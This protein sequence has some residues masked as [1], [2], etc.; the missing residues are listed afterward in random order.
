[1]TRDP[2]LDFP[3]TRR[4]G[5]AIL[6]VLQGVLPPSGLVLEVGAG[7]G[8][9]A[10]LFARAFPGLVWQPTDLDP[11][12]RRSIDAW[13]EGLANVRPALALDATADAWPV[14][15][16]D[17]VLSVNMIH[18]AP[19]QA[20]LGLVEGAGRVLPAGAAFVLYG[21]FMRN[22]RHTAESN[23]RF[24]ESLRAQDPSWGVRDLTDVGSAAVDHG[25]QLEA[26]HEMPANNLT[27]VFRKPA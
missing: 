26:V 2:R 1:M 11:A 13:C 25:F 24:D 6:A 16:A 18:I 14:S 19:W 21:P 22:G 10:A 3:A 23:A 15:A 9:H 8:Q 12:H 5:D 4:N 20:G 7:S 27:V 17:A